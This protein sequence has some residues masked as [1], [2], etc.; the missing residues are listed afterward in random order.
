MW[1]NALCAPNVYDALG[2]KTAMTDST[3][4]TAYTY[5]VLSRL[6]TKTSPGTNNTI[7]YTYDTEGN[8]LTS[9]DQNG[10][11]ITNTYDYL[12]RPATVHDSNGTTTY[13]YL[14]PPK[15]TSY[16]FPN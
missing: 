2:R 6:L 12:N 1:R 16:S 5:D 8:R 11:T 15:F 3:G 10:R 4:Q 9:V 13:S 14:F 7:T